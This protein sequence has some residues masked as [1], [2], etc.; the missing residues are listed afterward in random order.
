MVTAPVLIVMKYRLDSELLAST[1]NSRFQPPVWAAASSLTEIRSVSF[2]NQLAPMRGN[3][4]PRSVFVLESNLE[5]P[6]SMPRSVHALASGERR[7]VIV[8]RSNNESDMELGR[9]LLNAGAS[10]LWTTNDPLVSLERTITNEIESASRPSSHGSA[11]DH[12]LHSAPIA[13]SAREQEVVEVLFGSDDMTLAAVGEQLG[14]SENTVKNH[15]AHVRQKLGS[16]RAHNRTAL[17]SA[18][19]ERGWL[20]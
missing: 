19:L 17:R 6:A 5:A 14:I 15:L 13:L 3:Q 20:S 16:R 9:A 4:L 11:W 18:L 1:L 12:A 2:Q 10:S 7:V 8:S